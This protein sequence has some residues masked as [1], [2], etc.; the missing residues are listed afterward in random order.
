V[1]ALGLDY[2]YGYLT[3][4]DTS[5][6]MKINGE[7]STC[8]DNNFKDEECKANKDS[9]PYIS[10][11]FSKDSV[12]SSVMLAASETTLGIGGKIYVSSDTSPPVFMNSDK[13]TGYSLCAGPVTGDGSY[14]CAKPMRGR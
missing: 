9:W 10:F 2:S 13:I 5:A 7:P 12:V 8:S 1:I 11:T 3:T 6:T 14:D 4:A